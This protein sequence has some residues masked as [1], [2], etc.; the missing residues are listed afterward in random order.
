MAVSDTYFDISIFEDDLLPDHTFTGYR[1]DF[2]EE[3]IRVNTA[4]W[5][6]YEAGLLLTSVT[7][8]LTTGQG[9]NSNAQFN[10]MAAPPG[11]L[12]G[13]KPFKGIDEQFEDIFA[14]Y[15]GF[16]TPHMQH[17]LKACNL[18]F[19]LSMLKWASL[20]SINGATIADTGVLVPNWV[21]PPGPPVPMSGSFAENKRELALSYIGSSSL[22]LEAELERKILTFV[23][24]RSKFKQKTP[25]LVDFVQKIAKMMKLAVDEWVT[26]A[27]FTGGVVFSLWAPGGIPT[28]PIMVAFRVK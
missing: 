13:T 7:A 19:L 16:L 25:E 28:P 14:Q 8:L 23:F 10:N 17:F 2:V 9:Q 11:S 18:G 24:D 6:E 27:Y 15:G 12:V 4:I 26:K 5:K 21:S 1:R 22:D 3:I 20:Y